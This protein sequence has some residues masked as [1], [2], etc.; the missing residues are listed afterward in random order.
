MPT[1]SADFEALLALTGG[2]A[3]DLPGFGASVKASHLHYTVEAHA[4]FITGLLNHLQIERVGLIAHD[5]GA[6]GGLVFAQHAPQRIERL[7]LIDA[8]PLVDPL[9]FSR[10]A[11]ALR[12]PVLGEVIMGAVTRRRFKR[13]LQDAAITPGAFDEPRLEQAWR[14]FDQ[15]TQRAILRLLRD[16]AGPGAAKLGAAE[17]S[18]AQLR[19]PALIMWG[20]RDPWWPVN[21]AR[22]Y[23]QALPEARTSII[24]G[25]GHWPWLSSPAAA[26]EIAAFLRG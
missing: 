11:R 18:L 23:A 5:W 3:P 7:V 25:A 14:Q 20:E 24:E 19:A 22:R 26:A 13:T 21:I 12:A 1:A 6:G 17:T 4:S 9:E 16:A 15:G 8:L 2:I 10:L